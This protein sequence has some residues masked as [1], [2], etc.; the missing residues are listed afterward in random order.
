MSEIWKSEK[1]DLNRGY[2]SVDLNQHVPPQNCV[3]G[4]TWTPVTV[5]NATVP[6]NR[7]AATGNL[8]IHYRIKQVNERKHDLNIFKKREEKENKFQSQKLHN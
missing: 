8:G 1:P 6:A 3:I 5:P 4:V 2:E 7:T